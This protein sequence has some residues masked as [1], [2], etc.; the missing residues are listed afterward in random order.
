MGIFDRLQFNYDG[1][2]V[3]TLS[4]NAISFIDTMPPLLEPWQQ[5]D[6]ANN[7]VNGYNVNPV[8]SIVQ[9][10]IGYCNQ[11]V[12]IISPSEY[13]ESGNVVVSSEL[14]GSTGGITSLIQSANTVS[15][16]IRGFNGSEFIAHTNRI[17]GVTT[18]EQT[19][20]TNDNAA[21]LPHYQTAIGTGK[22]IM[23]ITRQSDNI[24]NNAPIMG[25]FTSLLIKDELQNYEL[26]ISTYASTINSSITI[27][28]VDDGN[29][30]V[31]ITRT[32]DLSSGEMGTI[33]TVIGEVN[34][35]LAI[36]RNHDEV[37]FK[38]SRTLADEYATMTQ[39]SDM[40]VSETD[41]CT[42]YIGSPKLLSRIGS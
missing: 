38:N 27:E 37:F 35:L 31:T 11:I 26:T 30:N 16:N 1:A 34:T 40:G 17:S 13:E 19:M 12:T 21:D 33:N 14:Q 24:G 9:N 32:S 4:S 6:M 2:G 36:R 3:E 8:G 23:Y 42:N 39:F 5:Q 25:N 18:I 41:L 20:A 28:S 7:Q 10:I 29:G 22:M 15:S